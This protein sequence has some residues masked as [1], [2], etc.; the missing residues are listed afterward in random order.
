MCMAQCRN[1]YQVGIVGMDM[2]LP[3]MPRILQT[4]MYPRFAPVGRFIDSISVR[5]VTAN[6]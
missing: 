1:V 5:D 4:Q 2:H 3:D 6:A